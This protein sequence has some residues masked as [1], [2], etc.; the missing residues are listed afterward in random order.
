LPSTIVLYF[1]DLAAVRQRKVTTIERRLAAIRKAHRTSRLM[2]PTEDIAVEQTMRGIRR[3]YGTPPKP[4]PAMNTYVLL[5]FYTF[6]ELPLDL[7]AFRCYNRNKCF[8]TLF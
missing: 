4:A 5:T 3:S 1:T 8:A 2:S 7:H 6:A